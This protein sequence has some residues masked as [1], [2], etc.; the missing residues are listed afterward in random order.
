MADIRVQAVSYSPSTGMIVANNA[1]VI[2]NNANTIAISANNLSTNA[3]AL[4]NTANS[5]AYQ[6]LSLINALNKY[7][8]IGNG[9]PEANVTANAGVIYLNQLGG[10]NTTLYV[11]ESGTGNTGWKGK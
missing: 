6:S 2:A 9:V 8:L 11:K 7:I 1:L 10:A 3:Y 4:A 5:I